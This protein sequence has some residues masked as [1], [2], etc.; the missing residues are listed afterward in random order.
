MKLPPSPQEGATGL[1]QIAHFRHELLTPINHILGLTEIQMDEAPEVGLC[2]YVPALQ[3]INT[4][5]RTLLAIIEGELAPFTLPSDLRQLQV[6]LE[7]AAR[8]A[9]GQARK[10]AGQLQA[11]GHHAAAEEIG[12]V[13][14]A[15]EGL[16]AISRETVQ[17]L[18][19]GAPGEL[20]K[21]ES[22]KA[23]PIKK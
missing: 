4:A 17:D 16:I 11:A 23:E 3:E 12:L 6:H 13:A 2:D 15:L 10:L 9:L 22:I 19:A 14:G 8:P 21:A 7:S 20:I 5:G 1:E 18:S